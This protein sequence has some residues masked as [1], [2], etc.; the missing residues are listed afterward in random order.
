LNKK[1]N[2]CR[3]GGCPLKIID[4]AKY[5][6]TEDYLFGEMANSIRVRDP[7][8]ITLEELL[9]ITFWKSPR[10]LHSVIQNDNA[11]VIDI[12]R[13]ALSIKEERNKVETLT[14]G[15]EGKRLKGV[16]VAIASAILTIIDPNRYSI[17]DFHVWHA[18]YG[19]TKL[20]FSTKDYLEYLKDVRQK[21][22]EE[23]VTPREIDKGLLI[24]DTGMAER[25][26]GSQNPG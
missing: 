11:G 6:K 14:S 25:I 23:G 15:V 4:Y 13:V 7:L 8:Y 9:Y 12:T 20:L 24:K 16:G 5:Y 1:I 22:K 17:I 26:I 3:N 21:A 2:N 18:L 19:E 10:N